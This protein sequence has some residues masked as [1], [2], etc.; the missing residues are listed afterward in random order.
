MKKEEEERKRKLEAGDTTGFRSFKEALEFNLNKVNKTSSINEHGGYIINNDNYSE[1]SYRGTPSVTPGSRHKS[2][3]VH[4]RNMREEYSTPLNPIG[5]NKS[6][7]LHRKAQ[8]HMKPVKSRFL[9]SYHQDHFSPNDS[10]LI[11]L[12]CIEEDLSS[13]SNATSDLVEP[14]Q[15][16]TFSRGYTYHQGA[17]P[18]VP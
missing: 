1:M 6:F 4:Q 17:H 3:I 5:E 16:I 8:S 12:K 13:R 9:K 11:P 18:K 10:L 7:V 15:N 14:R 2:M